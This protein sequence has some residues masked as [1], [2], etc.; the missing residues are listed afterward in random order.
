MFVKCFGF[1][2]ANEPDTGVKELTYRVDED[3]S[4]EMVDIL[5]EG[6][7]IRKA[8]VTADSPMAMIA[9]ITEVIRSYV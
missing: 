5:F 9:D 3:T 2:L 6:G 4:D 1:L 8:D 7:L